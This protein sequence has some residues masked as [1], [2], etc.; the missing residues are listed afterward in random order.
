MQYLLTNPAD[1][2][3]VTVQN[4]MERINQLE[5]S[6]KGQSFVEKN[7]VLIENLKS[8]GFKLIKG[9]GIENV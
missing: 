5:I 2:I 4:I 9:R 7:D 8:L 1:T 6:T 3:T